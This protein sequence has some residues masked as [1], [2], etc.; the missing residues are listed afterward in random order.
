MNGMNRYRPDQL[1]IDGML[2]KYYLGAATGLVA[3]AATGELFQFRWPDQTRLC[4]VRKIIV[5]AAASTLFA[6][7]PASPVTFDIVKATAWT[8]QGTGGTVLD[9]TTGTGRKRTQMPISL[10]TAGDVRVATTTGLGAGTKVLDS[11]ACATV[12]GI[13]VNGS[14]TMCVMDPTEI[15]KMED[16]QLD[17]PLVFVQNEGFVLRLTSNP[18]TGTLFVSIAI[19]WVETNAS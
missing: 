12:T 7:A 4:G 10:L 16:S 5:T 18:G 3:A 19:D 8:V 6:P 11:Q 15:I 13:P 17:Y 2:G 14:N 1:A 9:T